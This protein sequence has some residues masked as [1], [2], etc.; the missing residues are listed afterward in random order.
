[1][2][3]VYTVVEL[4]GEGG[5]GK[6][7]KVSDEDGRYFALKI[8]NSASTQ[9]RKRFKNEIVFCSKRSSPRI[10]PVLDYGF[11]ESAEERC[12]FY[13]MPLYAGTLRTLL[14][15]GVRHDAILPLFS[16]ILDGVQAAHLQE[17]VHRDLKP[18]NILHDVSSNSLVIADF[19]IA[20][21]TREALLTAVET[22]AQDRL[23]NFI[24][25]AP[26]QRVRGRDVG[27]W[28]DIYAL[29]LILNEM[30]TGEV[31][32]GTGHKLIG[33]VAPQYGYLDPLVDLMVRHSPAE[34]PASIVQIKQEL[35]ARGN[36]FVSQQRLNHLKST[37]I[38]EN[39]ID[40]PLIDNPIQ[41]VAV[42]YTDDGRLEFELDRT[43]SADWVRAFVSQGS[44][45]AIMGSE[46]QRFQ[47]LGNRALVP[48]VG[49]QVGTMQVVA[50]HFKNYVRT[51]NER[52]KAGVLDAQKRRQ[53]G[54]RRALRERIEREET[55]RKL[56][57]A[58]RTL[59]L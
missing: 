10:I 20:Q 39:E 28:A 17:V 53:E 50:D 56:R 52:Y 54:E 49:N 15:T 59:K 3:S 38:S 21:F 40:D 29:G 25:A 22:R 30:F 45:S 47:F 44:Y 46:P 9:Q 16:Q 6:V 14:K 58:A 4:V 12:P 32:Q 35:I 8:L 13:V 27:L 18:E 11:S 48:V 24:Y 23:A 55:L 2:S 41:P 37:V 34:R 5:A 1:M 57:E 43:P 42:S 31:L 19:G 36:E 51:A 33:S 26:E 7:Y